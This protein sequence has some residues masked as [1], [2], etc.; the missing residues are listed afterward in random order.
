MLHTKYTRLAQIK[1]I[2][3]AIIVTVFSIGSMMLMFIIS[4]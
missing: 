2:F 1:E 3:G 4:G